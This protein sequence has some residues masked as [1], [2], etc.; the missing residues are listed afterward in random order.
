MVTATERRTSL[1]YHRDG[2]KKRKDHTQTCIPPL[3]ESTVLRLYL[4][5]F[6]CFLRATVLRL[7]FAVFYLS[8]FYPFTRVA[9]QLLSVRIFS[10]IRSVPLALCHRL[11][12]LVMTL[13][14]KCLREIPVSRFTALFG[15][16]RRS[17]RT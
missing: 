3:V 13:V 12:M 7:C 11:L 14:W 2:L 6:Y 1:M 15:G 16:L 5:R 17:L 8:L 9:S 10:F 4:S